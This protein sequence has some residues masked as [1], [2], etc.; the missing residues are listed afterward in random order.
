MAPVYLIALK[1]LDEEEGYIYPGETFIA[2]HSHER[3]GGDLV[4]KGLIFG[5]DEQER[6]DELMA[7]YK[8]GKIFGEE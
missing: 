6:A 3:I 1:A 2:G 7:Q 8:A 5:F 4:D